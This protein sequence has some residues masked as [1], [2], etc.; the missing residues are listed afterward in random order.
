MMRL[1]KSKRAQSTMEYAL[2]IAVVIGV[3]SAMQIYSRRSLQARVQ[4]GLDRIPGVVATSAGSIFGTETQ[5]EPYYLANGTSSFV[6]NTTEGQETGSVTQQG[7]AR[8]LT[9]AT[10][11]RAGYQNIT[12]VE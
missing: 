12:G 3:F 10:S 1:F 8:A 7:G 2:L 9:G 4:G 11:S 5:Y 6:S